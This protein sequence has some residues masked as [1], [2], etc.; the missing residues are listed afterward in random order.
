MSDGT[1]EDTTMFVQ[2]EEVNRAICGLLFVT[3]LSPVRAHNDHG[4]GWGVSMRCFVCEEVLSSADRRE[5][6]VLCH[7]H[8]PS[9]H[10]VV[11]SDFGHVFELQ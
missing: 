11:T 2:I 1:R 6:F 4:A 3:K 7:C 9:S 5:R 10:D 8:A